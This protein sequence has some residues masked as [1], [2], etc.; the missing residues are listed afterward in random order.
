MILLIIIVFLVYLCSQLVL[1]TD[2]IFLYQLYLTNRLHLLY[3]RNK[4]LFDS[5]N[6][7]DVL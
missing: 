4:Q 7:K 3:D 2:I 5:M 1:T 6:V